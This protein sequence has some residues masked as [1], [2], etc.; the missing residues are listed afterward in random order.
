MRGLLVQ[1]TSKTGILKFA[2]AGA[3]LDLLLQRRRSS[4]AQERAF[5]DAQG[6]AALLVSRRGPLEDACDS[7]GPPQILFGGL[8][9]LWPVAIASDN[10]W[11]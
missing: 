10:S 8:L 7:H 1:P 4:L 2:A 11:L 6:V 5:V 9:Q 3:P